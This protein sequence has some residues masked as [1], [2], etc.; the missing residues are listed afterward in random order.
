MTFKMNRNDMQL[1]RC[2]SLAL[3]FETRPSATPKEIY[4]KFYPNSKKA[5]Q[6]RAF[7]R[8]RDLLALTGIVINY[9]VLKNVYYEARDENEPSPLAVTDEERAALG[10]ALRTMEFE[11]SFPLPLSLRLALNKI[12]E[13]LNDET[14]E[15]MI[16]GRM[17]YDENVEEQQRTLET[18]VGAFRQKKC[19]TFSYTNAK[20]AESTRLVAPFILNQFKGQWYMTGLDVEYAKNLRTFSVANISNLDI[21]EEPFEIPLDFSPEELCKPP[22]LWGDEPVKNVDLVIPAASAH[23]KTLITDGRGTCTTQAD[24]SVMWSTEYCDIDALCAFVLSENIA[25]APSARFEHEY[26]K[27]E[28]LERVV[29]AHV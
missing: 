3:Y 25:F 28:Y 29:A 21:T 4:Q 24:G 7:S 5:T 15:Y 22:H 13:R 1:E 23:R 2:L 14:D 26:L 19:V 6:E 11:P 20:G 16:F 9:D 12:D 27:N 8:D 18:I 10:V 17:S